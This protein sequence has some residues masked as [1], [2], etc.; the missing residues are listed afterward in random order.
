[1]I[2][3]DYSQALLNEDVNV[4]QDAVNKVAKELMEHT[5]K[6]SD[7]T[8]WVDWPE[9]YDHEE[10]ARL[11]KTAQRI[12]EDCEIFLVCGIGGS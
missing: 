3:G 4:Y 10:F 1:M 6:G 7:Y 2:K 8:G 11:K 5:G 12:R 9:N